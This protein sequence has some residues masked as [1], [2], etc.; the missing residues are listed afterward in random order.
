MTALEYALKMER[1]GEKYYS[2]QAEKN[3]GN[4]LQVVFALLA[5]EERKHADILEKQYNLSA[6]V[7][8]AR[9]LTPF[10]YTLVLESVKKTGR[11]LLTSDACERGSIL[12]DMARNIT[13]MA[14]DDL[15][16]PP[17]VVG[18]RNWVTPAFELE[19]YFFPQR[20]Q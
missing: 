10:D 20:S 18:A 14:F 6:E 9:S 8:D 16:A 19:G 12:N 15:D 4:K 17:V 3:K 7:I 11:I 1:D 2:E 13:E 5:E